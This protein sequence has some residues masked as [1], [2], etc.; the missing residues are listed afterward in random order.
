MLSGYIHFVYYMTMFEFMELFIY[1]GIPH[2]IHYSPPPPPPN[3]A[4]CTKQLNHMV[5]PPLPT[6]PTLNIQKYR[7]T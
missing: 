6:H 1:N 2:E 3:G 4:M 5:A 7:E